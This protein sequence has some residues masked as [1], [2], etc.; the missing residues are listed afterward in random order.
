MRFIALLL[1]SMPV[2]AFQ[3]ATDFAAQSPLEG[4]FLMK[5]QGFRITPE[6]QVL[7]MENPEA[8]VFFEY[9]FDG[10][11]TENLRLD[12][13]LASPSGDLTPMSQPFNLGRIEI[14]R[15]QIDEEGSWQITNLQLLDGDALIAESE[16]QVVTL[17]AVSELLVSRATVEELSR[18]ELEELGFVFNKD[19]YRAVKF[20]LSLVMGA[21]EV[22]VTVPVLVPAKR[23]EQFVA[24]IAIN[25]PFTPVDIRVVWPDPPGMPDLFFHEERETRAVIETS[26]PVLSLVVIPGKIHHL[27]SMFRVAVVTMNAAPEGVAVSVENLT[28]KIA[29]PAPTKYGHPLSLIDEEN[30]GLERGMIYVGPDGEAGT[31]DDRDAIE[32]SQEASAAYYLRGNVP[33]I[34][35]VTFDIRGSAAAGPDNH[36]EVRSQAR[37]RVYVRSP[38]YTVTFEHPE[39]IAAGET[40]DLT[41]HI[42]NIGSIPLNDF[43]IEIDPFRLVGVT[44][45]SGTNP[46]QSAGDIPVG[47]EAALTWRLRAIATGE[48]VATYYRVEE[49]VSSALQLSVGIAPTGERLSSKVLSFPMAFRQQFAAEL[50]QPTARLAKKLFDLSHMVEEE[51]PGHLLPVTGGVAKAFNQSLAFAAVSRSLGASSEQAH[52]SLLHSVFGAMDGV[53]AIDRLRREADRLNEPD[54][55]T[56]F[57]PFLRQL[58]AGRSGQ[59]L[60]EW[61]AQESR[62]SAGLAWVLVEGAEGAAWQASNLAGQV[63]NSDGRVDLPFS[64]WFDLGGG[65]RLAYLG[66]VTGSVTLQ[67]TGVAGSVLRCQL[68]FNRD[69]SSGLTYYDSEAWTPEGDV[70]LVFQPESERLQIEEQGGLRDVAGQLLPLTAFGVVGVKHLSPFEHDSADVQGRHLAF[71]FNKPLDLKTLEDFGKHLEVNGRPVQTGQ[72][73]NDGRFLIVKTAVPLGPYRTNHY[74]WLD[75]TAK[76]GTY[77]AA[78]EGDFEGNGFFSG[79]KVSGRVVDR[80]GSNVQNATVYLEMAATGADPDQLGYIVMDKVQPDVEGNYHFDFVPIRTGGIP[81]PTDTE[82][83]FT[84]DRELYRRLQKFLRAGTTFR[85]V[86]QLADGRYERREFHPQAPGQEVVAEFSFLNLGTIYGQVVDSDGTPIT[87]TQVIAIN[88]DPG[89]QFPRTYP[90]LV[91]TDENGMYRI[92]GL[93][94]GRVLLKTRARNGHLGYR[95]VNLSRDESPMRVDITFGTITA[96]MTG[97]VTAMQDGEAVPVADAYVGWW[98]VGTQPL[99]WRPHPDALI[100][101]AY[102]EIGRTDANGV[103]HL[104]DIPAGVGQLWVLGPDFYQELNLTIMGNELFTQDILITERTPP[105]EGIIRGQVVDIQGFPLEGMRVKE[106]S[107]TVMSGADGRFELRKTLYPSQSSGT[108]VTAIQPLLD[109]NGNLID[110][111][112][113][114][115]GQASV[116]ISLDRPVAEDVVIV[117]LADPR[118]SGTYMDAAGNPIPFAPVYNPPNDGLKPLIFAHT[119]HLGRFTGSLFDTSDFPLSYWDPEQGLQTGT[120]YFTGY[121][122]PKL[123]ETKVTVGIEGYQ[124][125]VIQEEPQS[126]VRV[127]LVDGE[128]APVIGRIFVRGYLPSSHEESMGM[129]TE[130]LLYQ[131]SSDVDGYAFFDP[132]NI[133]ETEIWG[134]HPLL[135]DT[136]IYR[137]TP[138]S[139]GPDDEV[140]TV[141][142]SYS[143]QNEPTNLYGRVTAADG[144]SP[145]AE[146]TLVTARVNGIKAV[147]RTNAEGWY[148]FDTLVSSEEKQMVDLIIYDPGSTTWTLDKISMDREMRFRHDTTLTGR[149]SVLVRLVDSDGNLVE[150]GAVSVSYFDAFY[151]EP[152]AVDEF[153]ETRIDPV[154]LTQQVLP[155][156]QEVVFENLPAGEV[157]LEARYG[158]GLTALKSVTLPRD[159]RR[160]EIYLRLETPASISGVFYDN[161]GEVVA[162][163]EIQLRRGRALLHQRVSAGEDTSEPGS[164]IFDALPMRK[165]SLVGRDPDTALSGTLEVQPTPYNPDPIVRLQIDPVGHIDGILQYDGEPL[166]NTRLTVMDGSGEWV[167]RK[168]RFVTSTDEFGRIDVRNL[169]LDNYVIRV[170]AKDGPGEGLGSVRISEA[171]ETATVEVQFRPVHNLALTVLNAD[172]TPSAFT[173][174]S[175]KRAGADWFR[176]AEGYTDE[177]GFVL[178]RNLEAGAYI[179][180]GLDERFYSALFTAFSISP[181]D[182]ETVQFQAQ[183]PGFGIVSGQVVDEFGVPLDYP[184]NVRFLDKRIEREVWNRTDTDGS[185]SFYW[186]RVPLNTPQII[187]AVSNRN[188]E[189]ETAQFVVTEHREHVVVNLVMRRMTSASGQVVF[190]DGMPVPY[191]QVW[192]KEP[193]E[194]I[195]QAD[196]NGQFV[197]EPVSTGT[198]AIFAKDPFSPRTASLAVHTEYDGES[199]PIPHTGLRLELQGVGSMSGNLTLSDGTPLDFGTVQLTHRETGA[200]HDFSAFV[201][202]SWFQTQMPLGTY[203]MRAYDVE[204]RTWADQ[205]PEITLANEGD[206]AVQDLVFQPSYEVRGR[207][208]APGRI[209]G[210]EDALVELWIHLG[211]VNWARTHHSVSFADGFYFLEHVYP[212]TYRVLIQ[213]TLRENTLTTEMTVLGDRDDADF[214]LA[215]TRSLSGTITDAA[216]LPLYPGTVMAFSMEGTLLDSANLTANGIFRL[217]ELPRDQV[218]LKASC[219]SGWFTFE[220]SV[221][222]VPGDNQVAFTGPETARVSGRLIVQSDQPLGGTV[223]LVYRGKSRGGR[224]QADGYFEIDRVPV[225]QTM[226][227]FASASGG[228]RTFEV[229][230]FS[231]DTDLGEILLDVM[232][233]ELPDL[234]EGLHVTSMPGVVRIPITENEEGSAFDPTK[235]FVA[236]NNTPIRNMLVMDDDAVVVRFVTIPVG[237]VRGRNLLTVG[238]YNTSGAKAYRKYECFIDPPGTVLDVAVSGPGVQPSAGTDVWLENGLRTQSNENGGAYF[239]GLAPGEVRVWAGAGDYGAFVTA[240]L[241]DANALVA[242]VAVPLMNVGAVEGLVRDRDGRPVAGVQVWHNNQPTLTDSGGFYRLW[243]YRLSQRSI[244]HV[245]DVLGVGFVDAPALTTVGATLYGQNIEIAPTGSLV[246]QVLDGA[247]PVTDVTVTLFHEDLPE[248][249]EQVVDVDGE[250]RFSFPRVPVNPLNLV[251][252]QKNAPR[253]GFAEYTGMQPGQTVT[254]DVQLEPV[255][256]LVGRLLDRDG[257]PVAGAPLNVVGSPSRVFATGETGAD[258]RFQLNEVS[259]GELILDAESQAHLGY[260]SRPFTLNQSSLDLGD[261]TLQD[262]LAPELTVTLPTVWDPVLRPVLRYQVSDDRRLQAIQVVVDAYPEL[263]VTQELQSNS[264]GTLAMPV[265][266]D[267]AYGVYP[268]T[269]TLTDH[270]GQETVWQGD[271]NVADDIVPPTISLVEP[272]DV[273]QLEEGSLFRLVVQVT[274]DVHSLKVQY[275]GVDVIAQT[276][277]AGFNTRTYDVRVPPVTTS[278]R[279]ELD[280]LAYDRKGN[281]GRLGLPVDVI[282]RTFSGAPELVFTSHFDSQ[283]MP[284]NLDVPLVLHVGARFSD[285][286]GLQRARL[287]IDGELVYEQTLTGT[288]Q[289]VSYQY[290]LPPATAARTQLSLRWEVEDLGFN[291]A[292]QTIALQNFEGEVFDESNPL[293]IGRYAAGFEDRSYVLVGG[294]HQIDGTHRL[295]NLIMVNG[296]VVQQ[297]PSSGSLLGDAAVTHLTVDGVLIVDGGAQFSADRSGFPE[298]TLYVGGHAATN[299]GGLILGETDPFQAFG[300]AVEPATVAAKRG[301]GAL[302]LQAARLIVSGA[303]SADGTSYGSSTYG[304]GGSVWLVSEQL[305]GYGQV[306]ANG[307][308]PGSSV[309]ASKAGG[310][311]V[312]IYGHGENLNLAAAG[313]GS[314]GHGTLYL[315]IPDTNFADGTRDILRVQG[316]AEGRYHGVTPLPSLRAVVGQDITFVPTQQGPDGY[317]DKLITSDPLGFDLFRGFYV[318]RDGEPQNAARIDRVAGNEI[319]SEP[320]QAFPVFQ[321]GDV[322]RIGFPFDLVE[323]VDDGRLGVYDEIF[324]LPVRLDDGAL[325]SGEGTL[326]QLNAARLSG[327]RPQLDGAFQVGQWAL[328]AGTTLFL[329]GS[330]TAAEL[331]VPEGAVVQTLNVNEAPNMAIHAGT[332]TIDGDLRAL[333]NKGLSNPLFARHGGILAYQD[334]AGDG[335]TSGSLVRPTAFAGG[336]GGMLHLT[337]DNLTLNGAVTLSDDGAAGGALFEGGVMTGA[338]AV[339][340]DGANFT[341]QTGYSSGGRLALHVDDLDGFSGRLSAY[342]Y[343]EGG[344]D[345]DISGAGT[346]FIKTAVDTDGRLIVDNGGRQAPPNSTVLPVFGTRTTGAGTTE[347]TMVGEFPDY[348][349][350][351]GMY[352]QLEGQTPQKIV[353]QTATS[354][355]LADAIPGLSAGQSVTAFHRFDEIVARGGATVFTTDTIKVQRDPVLDGGAIDAPIERDGAGGTRTFADG[356]G[357]LTVDDGT[358]VYELDNFQ[359]VVQFPLNVERISLRNGASLTYNADIQAQT[360]E[361]DGATLYSGVDGADFGLIAENVT[362]SNGALWTARAHS[363]TLPP[364]R[365]NADIAG[366]LTV[367]ATSSIVVGGDNGGDPYD[368][369]YFH[370]H[371]AFIYG[372]DTRGRETDTPVRGSFMRPTHRVERGGGALRLRCGTLDLAGTLSVP[373]TYSGDQQTGGGSIWLEAN[374]YLGQGRIDTGETAGRIAIY[375]SGDTD[376]LTRYQI[377]TQPTPIARVLGAG[378]LYLKGPDQTYGELVVSQNPDGGYDAEELQRRYRLTGIAGPS[379]L[380]VS[381]GDQDPDPLVIDDPAWSDVVPGLAGLWLRF[382]VAGTDYE[383]QVRDNTAGRLLLEPPAVGSLPATVP[384]GTEL[385]FVLKLDRLTLSHGAQ[386]HFAGDVELGDLVI[387]DGTQ[388]A[389]LWARDLKGLPDDWTLRDRKLRLTLDE[390]SFDNRSIT[391]ENSELWLD[392]PITLQRLTLVNSA[393]KHSPNLRYAEDYFYRAGIH[394]SASEVTMDAQSRFAGTGWGQWEPAEGGY[395]NHGGNHTTS[396]LGAYGS[397]FEPVLPGAGVSYSGGR[398]FLRT[399]QLNGGHFDV[400]SRSAAGSIWLELGS[401]TGTVH[402]NAGQIE[403]YTPNHGGGRIAVVYDDISQAQITTDTRAANSS[404]TYFHKNR[405]E[406]YGTLVIDNGG[407][408]VEGERV[409]VLPSF[410]PITLDANF[411]LSQVNGQTRLWLPGVTLADWYRGYQLALNE[412]TET[413]WPIRAIEPGEGGTAVFLAGTA[414]TLAAGDRLAPVVRLSTLELCSGCRLEPDTLPVITDNS[415]AAGH[416]F[417]DGEQNFVEPPNIVDG[418][419]Q[420]DGFTMEIQQAVDYQRVTLRNGAALKLTG[421]VNRIGH[422]E[423]DGGSLLVTENTSDTPTLVLDQ[424]DLTGTAVLEAASIE[425]AGALT[426]GADALLQGRPFAGDS[427]RWG[428]HLINDAEDVIVG[429][430]P[431]YLGDP[432][433]YGD[434]RRP[435]YAIADLPRLRVKADVAVIDG[436]MRPGDLSATL[437]KAGGTLWLEVDE[438]RGSGH[439]HA[440]AVPMASSS[441]LIGGGGRVAVYYRENSAWQGTISA[442]GSVAPTG[443]KIDDQTGAGTV[444]T[445]AVAQAHGVLTVV[446][447]GRHNYAGST[448]LSGLGRYRLGAQAVVNGNQLE[449]PDAVFANGLAGLTLVVDEDGTPQTF[450]ITANTA[451]TITVDQPLPALAAGTLISAQLHLDALYLSG[452]ARL[453]TPDHL[454]LH[455]SLQPATELD[456]GSDLWCRRLT[457]S[458]EDLVLNNGALGLR[459]DETT[460]LRMVQVSDATLTLNGRLSLDQLILGRGATLTHTP[461]VLPAKRKFD[462]AVEGIQLQVATLQVAADAAINADG[463]GYPSDISGIANRSHGGL[464]ASVSKTYGSPFE[465]QMAGTYGGG[466]LIKIDAE[467]MQIDGSLTARGLVGGSIWLNT[468]LVRGSGVISVDSA[469][470]TTQGGSAGRV[471]LYYDDNQLTQ[472]PSARSHF[473]THYSDSIPQIGAGT[474][475]LRKRGETDGALY[476]MN[477]D[478]GDRPTHATPLAAVGSHTLTETPSD[479]RV[480]VQSGVAW[481]PG[482]EGMEIVDLQTNATYRIVAHTNNRLTLDRPV[483][484]APTAG[485]AYRG[486]APINRI[487]QG[488]ATFEAAEPAELD[489][490]LVDNYETEPPTIDAVTFT[491]PL[492][493]AALAGQS[494]QLDL[495]ASDASGI[496]AVSVTFDGQTQNGSGQGPWS[497]TWTAPNVV[498]ATDYAVAIEVRDTIGNIRR[499]QRTVAVWPVDSEVPVVTVESPADNTAF[500]SDIDVTTRVSVTDNYGLSRLVYQFGDETRTVTVADKAAG[501]VDEQ[502]WRLPITVGD[503]SLVLTVEAYDTSEQRGQTTLT[504]T[505]RDTTPPPTPSSAAVTPG[506]DTLALTWPAVVDTDGDLAGYELELVDV[507]PAVTLSADV[508]SYQFTGLTPD[509]AYD[510]RLSS[511]DQS[512]NLS[513]AYLVSANTLSASG[514]SQIETPDAWWSFDRDLG[515]QKALSFSGSASGADV[516]LGRDLSRDAAALTLVTWFRLESTTGGQSLIAV[517]PSEGSY[518][519]AELYTSSSTLYFVGWRGSGSS[520]SLSFSGLV[521]DR[522]YRVAGSLD[523][524][525]NT[526]NLYLDG[527]LVKSRTLYGSGNTSDIAAESVTLGRRGA[528]QYYLRGALRDAQIWRAP[529][530]EADAARDWRYPGSAGDSRRAAAHGFTLNP[531]YHLVAAWPLDGRETDR[532]VDL[533]G[534]QSHAVPTGT[535]SVD[536]SENLFAVADRIGLLPGAAGPQRVEPH[537]DFGRALVFDGT[538][539]EQPWSTPVWSGT[540][541]ASSILIRLDQ[542]P[543]ALGRSMT[544]YRLG[545]AALT[546]DSSDRLVWQTRDGAVLTDDNALA[547]GRWYQVTTLRQNETTHQLL[548]D[549][550]VVASAPLTDATQPDGAWS[551]AGSAAGNDAFVGAVDEWMLWSTQPQSASL[552]QLSANALDSLAFGK[553]LAMVGEVRG[554]VDGDQVELFWEAAADAPPIAAWLVALDDGEPVRLGADAVSHRFTG[555]GLGRD[556]SIRVQA[557][558]RAGELSQPRTWLGATL[559]DQ[560]AALPGPAPMV[561][562]PFEQEGVLLKSMTFPDNDAVVRITP[563]SGLISGADALTMSA[564]VRMPKGVTSGDLFY[565]GNPASRFEP[566]RIYLSSGRVNIATRLAVNQSTLTRYSSQFINDGAFH[567]I[568]VVVD[569]AQNQISFYLDGQFE[570][571]LGTAASSPAPFGDDVMTTLTL[572]GHGTTTSRMFQGELA[573]VQ[574]WRAAWDADD[575]TYDFANPMREGHLTAA[576]SALAAGS[577]LLLRSIFDQSS[578]DTV[579]DRSGS[580]LHGTANA[581]VWPGGGPSST[582]RDLA[583]G[584]NTVSEKVR[585]DTGKYGQAAHFNGDGRLSFTVPAG[586]TDNGFSMSWWYRL[587]EV[588]QDGAI[589]AQSDA[590]Q[591]LEIGLDLAARPWLKIGPALKQSAGVALTPG[592]WHHF[593][594]TADSTQGTRLF[595]DG[596]PVA[597][598]PQA[599]ILTA[600]SWRLGHYSRRSGG[601]YGALDDLVMWDQV[602]A[603]SLIQRLSQQGADEPFGDLFEIAVNTAEISAPRVSATASSLRF[604]WQVPGVSLA[605]ISGYRVYRDGE[606]T[607]VFVAAPQTTHLWDGLAP[608]TRHAV[609]ITTVDRHGNE[610]AGVALQAWTSADTQVQQQPNDPASWYDFELDNPSQTIARFPQRGSLASFG[611]TAQPGLIGA[612]AV[613]VAAWIRT[614]ATRS[615][616]QSLFHVLGSNNQ[617]LVLFD[618]STNRPYFRAR[619]GTTRSTYSAGTSTDI[620]DGK[621]HRYVG[622]ADFANQ[623]LKVYLDGVLLKESSATFGATSMEDTTSINQFRVS[624]DSSYYYDG[625]LWNLQLWRGAFDDQTAALD[626]LNTLKTVDQHPAVTHLTQDDLV[627]HW[628]LDDGADGTVTDT[629]GQERHGVATNLT[630]VNEMNPVLLANDHHGLRPL[631]FGSGKPVDP[632]VIGL[633]LAVSEDGIGAAM[634]ATQTGDLTGP[635]TMSLWFKPKAGQ[636]QDLRRILSAAGGKLTVTLDGDH[637]LVLGAG[638]AQAADTRNTLVMD[639]WYH[640][641]ISG[642]PG[643]DCDLYLD[644]HRVARVPLTADA[645]LD[646]GDLVLGGRPGPIQTLVAELD[647]VGLWTERLTTDQVNW[648]RQ[649]PAGATWAKHS[650]ATATATPVT[651]ASPS[652]AAASALVRETSAEVE[653]LQGET[654]SRE[655]YQTGNHL[656]L[657]GATLEVNGSLIARSI[658]LRNGSRLTH[659]SLADG[660]PG[661]LVVAAAERIEIDR[662]SLID[663]DGRGWRQSGDGFNPAHAVP[664]TGENGGTAYGSLLQPTLPGGGKQGGGA[665]LLIAP[666]IVLDGQILARGIG[667]SAG[668]SVWLQTADLSGHGLIDVS[669]GLDE[670]GRGGAGRIAVHAD[671]IFRFGGTLTNGLRDQAAILLADSRGRECRLVARLPKINSRRT[672]RPA[673]PPA[674]SLTR[675]HLGEARWLGRRLHLEVKTDVD[676]NRY[677]G[678]PA[679]TP[680]GVVHLQAV[681]QM[682]ADRWMVELSGPREGRLPAV[683]N[684]FFEVTNPEVLLPAEGMLP[685]VEP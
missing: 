203:T 195:G 108:Q 224:V 594:L 391:L 114:L 119:D 190:A 179:I 499:V 449:D 11:T 192:V 255:G 333:P 596:R 35:D 576:G 317:R 104:D 161:F 126:K 149:N 531:D 557:E 160:L 512:G 672:L 674:L 6:R 163:G 650:T 433:V 586:G 71:M 415:Y 134:E 347:T 320:D 422:L 671:R 311:R 477:Q 404:G 490:E 453:W 334:V 18:D 378:T 116:P 396:T 461:L 201:D 341:I 389:S 371:S 270:F 83:P 17:D 322:V 264:T 98:G 199:L 520:Y 26:P 642:E 95:S 177:N 503:E 140:P 515:S 519:T 533:S 359:L 118:V 330:L 229:G 382:N 377:V 141:V 506:N 426:L 588:G 327:T 673:L 321:D 10:E 180:D 181:E 223:G 420:L 144:V 130:G 436:L 419:L 14:H 210:I 80:A 552:A 91:P 312:A 248:V 37:A 399:D 189:S 65:R 387:E 548:R 369:P 76:D 86:V 256:Q 171:G 102:N 364:S 96:D 258:G 367:D 254:L 475:Y 206:S 454:V 627:L 285:P 655:V 653:T 513:E 578:G 406:D 253:A 568:V 610:S 680:Q 645:G 200:V 605:E 357:E 599:P 58:A 523:F 151:Q 29:F 15:D 620:N 567:R 541:F 47:G 677:L 120:N 7:L 400:T 70:K 170:S 363:E 69:G 288:E 275:Q 684:F 493:D 563:P 669:G 405:A 269:A 657:D 51:V 346:I 624:A 611:D 309:S 662:E 302:Y 424:A 138:E 165:Y 105:Q 33:G 481:L 219:L 155:S 67:P 604:D 88:E 558:T 444:F 636:N 154:V 635:F 204:R 472:L 649:N 107:N 142:L 123:A 522:W 526:M 480:L 153:G 135:G 45:E 603:P 148:W 679:Q 66:G 451:T 633:G 651:E 413:L 262:D 547:S 168:L 232:P 236:L 186:D 278:G 446:G 403:G 301:G 554:V 20:N 325:V 59:D 243:P 175:V 381:G 622:V 616:T 376:F 644:G 150:T 496:A 166:G 543:S 445:K 61:L 401:A 50:A 307:F 435:W 332:L 125:L 429:G 178:L 81:V 643:L 380:T 44:M 110:E 41:M 350:F 598:L 252:R 500:D 663:L 97:R 647:Q 508:T 145:A 128:G 537:G 438:L 191:A 465:P 266:A 239:Y 323:V 182:P 1:L 158:N 319:V 559:T 336:D 62:D 539:A 489:A 113:R 187:N 577:D 447:N 226:S 509:T 32:P 12:Y 553:S 127:R 230:P 268:M 544:I 242:K 497:F 546:I 375:H 580:G 139:L 536:Q 103:Y 385:H 388:L 600:E 331:T 194:I 459:I 196:A 654:Y 540:S 476:L 448:P 273:L 575:V 280:V 349:D 502:V 133:R 628:R 409:T 60:L 265:P 590:D 486:R 505:V 209:E 595:L 292:D 129:I 619:A 441:D 623:R 122:F 529:W 587:P 217:S 440:D 36:F 518:R 584:Q 314:A 514:V 591:G 638:N 501:T 485:W 607:G 274:S 40:Y 316:R 566:L 571:V 362:L 260:V 244:L 639:R 528:N 48:V 634:P 372:S 136:N 483:Q 462:Y 463:K 637:R 452:G 152:Q 550:A 379:V 82:N 173:R 279:I 670:V 233:P 614:S 306:R 23:S 402:L 474:V 211:G 479:P 492:A 247:T 570:K 659:P 466:G 305:Q 87:D 303:I 220:Q 99:R 556:F 169:P 8:S 74:R 184:V 286:D 471:A 344:L 111:S 530:S 213:D 646:Q 685:I 626:Y 249:F 221:N 24:P 572:G 504:L 293:T 124:N 174:I 90:K 602:L 582:I 338:G 467:T 188:M 418:W 298:H 601:L 423:L 358:Q 676:L 581:A 460:N 228:T 678:L 106:G 117:A 28:A 532:V 328:N 630:W 281:E 185:S 487:Y 276:Y 79:V 407:L 425:V 361:L 511:R 55:V 27:K 464:V 661:V 157:T 609:R 212:G 374:Q 101:F 535:S 72:V 300:S 640:L 384:Q 162:D 109:R 442:R 89:R 73:Q 207:V 172:G 31:W 246:G 573:D 564:W 683:L 225:G 183:F 3:E 393:V 308:L 612:E 597:R 561:Y 295:A 428:G 579:W 234:P 410:D 53:A 216:N 304:A 167:G 432:M 5:Q 282:D 351:V 437:R 354:L 214:E 625:D 259:Y 527:Q 456:D 85:V 386:L 22:P 494:F 315:R 43:D 681:Q 355:T 215:P 235:T 245:N 25:D 373:R 491:L 310:G 488:W 606:A 618:L 202:G 197:I 296:A 667:Y 631:T 574:L 250:G 345:R 430:L 257:N 147:T 434:F 658:E 569:F 289:E 218:V 299:H 137:F 565:L 450:V 52:L 68:V 326:V 353:A 222:L 241:S 656:V 261:L 57:E 585:L 395:R 263:A 100:T 294:V 63:A 370:E 251:A 329:N 664:G 641:V 78:A 439:V 592:V 366:T 417:R 131:K 92:E 287:H 478:L 675:D 427:F 455:G 632:G 414:P 240:R 660:N 272:Q 64:D 237:A 143:S 398:I 348:A 198:T 431:K 521:A 615:G 495:T 613:T 468:G 469:T 132:I 551:L 666:E 555:V 84:F 38:E 507:A 457:L 19:D 205:E 421:A 77:L 164:F 589:L 342:G 470:T 283:P 525:A 324:D 383:T 397:L 352:L 365:V 318:W 271:L 392:K 665:V 682:G 159:G 54:L 510:I 115:R 75:V 482:L 93:E 46:T 593:T 339:M 284:L 484:P 297:T 34:H 2:F 16:P 458:S 608:D 368:Y 156:Q 498:S 545:N 394:L 516:T 21:T 112:Q 335:K 668:G 193:L 277:R 146:G 30:G 49:G 617:D 121:R 94:V 443:D 291:S 360:V 538:Q 549:G 4:L 313:G 290:Q 629:S 412:N 621:W 337:F 517:K 343:P 562:L 524:A 39:V 416:V 238:V 542:L 42:N 267:I 208:L 56:A 411:A 652:A 583:S 227:L 356:S 13:L 560:T 648:L 176:G 473:F 231:G 408:G 340:A 534:N 9:F 390:P